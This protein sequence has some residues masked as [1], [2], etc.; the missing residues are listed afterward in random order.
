MQP[1]YS[2]AIYP[3]HEMEQL[4]KLQM[5][6]YIQQQVF[7]MR[8]LQTSDSSQ[9]LLAHLTTMSHLFSC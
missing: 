9:H 2:T 7:L 1:T 4:L 6:V 5:H 8:S 3:M